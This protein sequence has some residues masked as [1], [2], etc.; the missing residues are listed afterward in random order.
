MVVI[1]QISFQIR[2]LKSGIFL[3]GQ[4]LKIT[5]Q[6]SSE[7]STSV[8]RDQWPTRVVY[9]LLQI[10]RSILAGKQLQ[11]KQSW[12][13]RKNYGPIKANFRN[14][15]KVRSWQGRQLLI[16]VH[17]RHTPTSPHNV[18][19]SG[20]KRETERRSQTQQQSALEINTYR[21]TKGQAGRDTSIQA[22]SKAVY[23][24]ASNQPQQHKQIT[25]AHQKTSLI[26][27]KVTNTILSCN[28]HLT[29]LY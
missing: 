12:Q 29:T 9:W 3:L 6:Y 18:I 5:F 22:S 7:F 17:Q 11:Y 10:L 28:F 14:L 19:T 21:Q 24:T 23:K 2:A 16:I 27:N 20:N 25:S 1:T 4:I 15:G 8:W 13:T 26:D